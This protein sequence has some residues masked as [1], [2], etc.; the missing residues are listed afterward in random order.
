MFH[1]LIGSTLSAASVFKVMSG[2]SGIFSWLT[3]CISQPFSSHPSKMHFFK[4]FF[5]YNLQY[6]AYEIKMPSFEK[7]LI[8][9]WQKGGLEL[10]VLANNHFPEHARFH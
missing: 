4:L 3:L 9:Y 8:K 7:S 6:I 1:S 5:S 2:I 10:E